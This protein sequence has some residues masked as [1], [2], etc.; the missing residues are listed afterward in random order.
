VGEKS[1]HHKLDILGIASHINEGQDF[2]TCFNSIFDGFFGQI[3]VDNIAFAI[4]TNNLIKKEP[5]W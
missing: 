5:F 2:G 4:K 1:R 3:M